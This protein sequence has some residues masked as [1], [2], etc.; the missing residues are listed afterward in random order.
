MRG[1]HEVDLQLALEDQRVAA[2]HAGGHGSA[3]I[4]KCLMPVEAAQLDVFPVQ[5][6]ALRG[7]AGFAEAD[8]HG[9]FVD[10]GAALVQAGGYG[11]ELR[12]IQVPK[13]DRSQ[14]GKGQRLTGNRPHAGARRLH[15]RALETSMRVLGEEHPDTLTSTSN[16]SATLEAQGDHDGALRLLRKCLAGRRKVLGEDHPATVTT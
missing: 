9:A 4:G 1:A 3:D 12:V 7:E 14:V 13:I 2:L 11:V 10:G 15:E 6:E 8:T 5:H 16:L